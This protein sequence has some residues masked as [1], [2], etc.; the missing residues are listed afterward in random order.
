MVGLNWKDAVLP[1][2]VLGMAVGQPTFVTGGSR[3]GN[4]ADGNY[5]WEWFYKLQLSD[6]IAVTPAVFYL[7]RPQGQSTGRGNSFDSFGYLV[8]TTFRF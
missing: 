8:Q 5:A 3:G 7:S 2:N 4:T 6:T 1:G